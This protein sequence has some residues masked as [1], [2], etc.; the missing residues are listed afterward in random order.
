MVC[1]IC[2]ISPDKHEILKRV[3]L[4]NSRDVNKKSVGDLSKVHTTFL[5]LPIHFIYFYQM[6]E[7]P[8]H[9]AAKYGHRDVVRLLL[10]YGGDVT[11]TTKD[12]IIAKW[13]NIQSKLFL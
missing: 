6:R 9:V 7:T 5:F 11:I 8:L 10:A 12:G 13:A 2:E 4:S 3:L 1:H